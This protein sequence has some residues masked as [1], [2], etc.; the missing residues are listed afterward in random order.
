MTAVEGCEHALEFENGV[1]RRGEGAIK[2]KRPERR[3]F[4]E[5]GRLFT[6]EEVEGG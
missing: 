4:K 6:E 1:D 2:Q 3:K 5:G